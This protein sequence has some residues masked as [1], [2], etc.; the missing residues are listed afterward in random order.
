MAAYYALGSPKR[1]MTLP[2]SPG[3]AALEPATC[4]LG[5]SSRIP[6]LLA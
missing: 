4:G 1:S 2:A 6:A 3:S 5:G